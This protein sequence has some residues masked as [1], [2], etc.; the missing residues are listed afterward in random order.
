MAID[1]RSRSKPG[2]HRLR[3]GGS[4]KR[5]EPGGTRRRM[6]SVSKSPESSE[7]YSSSSDDYSNKND[8][9]G[10]GTLAI[11][12]GVLALLG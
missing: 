2:T 5:C 1:P 11:V 4:S 8:G 6:T 3:M 9:P 10:L 7:P 12:V